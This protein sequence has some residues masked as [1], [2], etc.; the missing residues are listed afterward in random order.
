MEFWNDLYRDL[1]TGGFAFVSFL[2]LP[3]LAISSWLSYLYYVDH[4]ANGGAMVE[5]DFTLKSV[6]KF[7]PFLY[8]FTMGF[9]LVG[10]F[11]IKPDMSEDANLK[12]GEYK[13][14]YEVSERFDKLISD[15]IKMRYALDDGKFSKQEYNAVARISELNGKD[16]EDLLREIELVGGE[17][18]IQKYNE[19]VVEVEDY[20]KNENIEVLRNFLI[21]N[22]ND[23]LIRYIRRG[24]AYEEYSMA[25]DIVRQLT[26]IQLYDGESFK[27]VGN[28]YDTKKVSELEAEF[29]DGLFEHTN[30]F[31]KSLYIVI[32]DG[33][34][35]E[36]EQKDSG[37]VLRTI[38]VRS[39]KDD[40]VRAWRD[41]A[42]SEREYDMFKL[43]D[44]E[45]GTSHLRVVDKLIEYPESV[46]IENDF[47]EVKKEVRIKL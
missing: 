32:R 23:V 46:S 2:L 14:V 38:L 18:N 22:G 28:R 37:D 47:E 24:D 43:Y 6:F 9:L 1:F 29:M 31:R 20:I 15:F 16:Y 30:E 19:V 8:I 17:T 41:G 27:E 21:K 39:S 10:Y 34:I 36:L 11:V 33:L 5:A 40:L 42:V 3:F 4:E 35:D 44:E 25:T 12:I 13:E 7:L 26:A 45:F